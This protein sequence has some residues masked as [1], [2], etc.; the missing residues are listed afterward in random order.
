MARRWT[1]R[2]EDYPVADVFTGTPTPIEPQDDPGSPAS[3]HVLDGW[4]AGPNFAGHHTVLLWGCGTECQRIVV[5]DAITGGVYIEPGPTSHGAEFR[6]DSARL[7][8]AP[9]EEIRA[10]HGDRAPSWLYP[11]Y[12]RWTGTELVQPT[13]PD[14]SER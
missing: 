4:R 6:I 3:P 14:G 8:A 1:P 11:R 13:L 5:V 9:R 12:Y 10:D 7:I 2:F